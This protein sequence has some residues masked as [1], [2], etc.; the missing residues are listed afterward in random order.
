MGTNSSAC[1]TQTRN[2]SPFKFHFLERLMCAGQRP[3]W[4]PRCGAQAPVT[5]R[6]PPCFQDSRGTACLLVHAVTLA[7]LQGE[8]AGG[9]RPLLLNP[10]RLGTRP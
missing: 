5:W 6:V 9:P 1:Q 7:L 10:A 2:R 4:P 8:G 3:T